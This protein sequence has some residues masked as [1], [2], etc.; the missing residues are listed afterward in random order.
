M[1]LLWNYVAHPT[2]GIFYV[3]FVA[4]DDVNMDM[5]YALPGRRS[6]VNADIVTIRLEFLVKSHA[7]LGDQPH[8][9]IDL[10]WCQVEEAGYMASRDDQGMARAHRVGITRTVSKFMFQ[11]NATRIFA[12][13]AWIVRIPLF[14]SFFYSRQTSTLLISSWRYWLAPAILLYSFAPRN[15][16]N[17]AAEGHVKNIR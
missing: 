15:A 4:R 10:F 7:L 14:F 1:S 16:L 6:D 12:E 9:G 8:A 5:E 11:R 2:L 3:P 13:Q 17:R